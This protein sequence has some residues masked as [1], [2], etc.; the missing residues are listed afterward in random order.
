M[1]FPYT[2]TCMGLVNIIKLQ[3]IIIGLYLNIP[4]TLPF[5]VFQ[6]KVYSPILSMWDVQELMCHCYDL[7]VYISL[8]RTLNFFIEL[9][10]KEPR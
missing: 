1:P 3:W 2:I 10:M 9:D 5:L 4:V 8:N 7:R 6:V